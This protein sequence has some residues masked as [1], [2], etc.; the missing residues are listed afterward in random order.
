MSLDQLL[1][2]TYF[3]SVEFA[4]SKGVADTVHPNVDKDTHPN[5]QALRDLK[6]RKAE[7]KV[8][9]TKCKPIDKN[10]KRGPSPPPPPPPRPSTGSGLISAK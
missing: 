3:L 6:R 1:N 4:K 2:V 9:K 8:S 5:A 10:G 7:L